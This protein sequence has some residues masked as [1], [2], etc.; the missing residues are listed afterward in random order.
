MCRHK[1]EQLMPVQQSAYYK[2][3]SAHTLLTFSLACCT[4]AFTRRHPNT[5]FRKKASSKVSLHM[6]QPGIR[7]P[8]SLS[9]WKHADVSNPQDWT[10]VCTPAYDATPRVLCRAG[11]PTSRSQTRAGLLSKARALAA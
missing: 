5:C 6:A 2:S 8:G 9:F 10:T 11:P 7:L 3:D 4:A 1:R